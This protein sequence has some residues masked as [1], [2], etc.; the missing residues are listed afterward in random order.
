MKFEEFIASEK[1][2]GIEEVYHMINDDESYVPN[3]KAE[4]II[5]KDADLSFWYASHVLKGRFELGEPAIAKD[6][7]R[8]YC[9]ASEV[10]KGRFELG[11]KAIAQDVYWAYVY[12]HDIIKGRFKLG[13]KVMLKSDLANRYKSKFMKVITTYKEDDNGNQA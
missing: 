4:K 8:A 1:D 11:E 2:F 6:P 3:E 5:A 7:C 13:E 12:V 10:I 9:Y